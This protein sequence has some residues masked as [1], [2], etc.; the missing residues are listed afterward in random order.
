MENIDEASEDTIEHV[1]NTI[2]FDRNRKENMPGD[3]WY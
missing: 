1:Y 2:F 3:V